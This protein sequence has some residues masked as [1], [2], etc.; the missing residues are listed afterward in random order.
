MAREGVKRSSKRQEAKRCL[1]AAEA[2]V[3]AC[4]SGT[5]L[6]AR[7]AA[8]ALGLHNAPGDKTKLM[9]PSVGGTS[10]GQA[11]LPLQLPDMLWK[12]QWTLWHV[13]GSLQESLLHK[14]GNDPQVSHCLLNIA[15]FW[16]AGM[17]RLNMNSVQMSTSCPACLAKR[18]T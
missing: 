7:Q 9:G 3:T 10:V 16:P 17:P 11:L 18:T 6:L 15:G 12:M 5:P 1:R 4:S 13:S 2:Q 14:W 8:A